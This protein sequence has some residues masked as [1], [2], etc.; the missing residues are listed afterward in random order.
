MFHRYLLDL[1]WK[2]DNIDQVYESSNDPHRSNTDHTDTWL[3]NW[4]NN[5][6]TDLWVF[7]CVPSPKYF[8][9]MLLYSYDTLQ[10]MQFY[11][12]LV[13]IHV[14]LCKTLHINFLLPYYYWVLQSMCRFNNPSISFFLFVCLHTRTWFSKKN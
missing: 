12:W 5:K 9:L 3:Q 11:C 1:L 6:N 2:A 10:H 8:S 14:S 4:P 7:P 13:I